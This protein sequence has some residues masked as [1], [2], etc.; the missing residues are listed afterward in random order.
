MKRTKSCLSRF[1]S[2][3]YSHLQFLRA[4][5]HSVGAHRESLRHAAVVQPRVNS[6]SSSSDDQDEDEAS[7]APVPALMTSAASE[8]AAAAAALASDDCCQTCV[9]RGATC[10]R[11]IGAVRSCTVLR[12]LCHMYAC[13]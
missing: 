13:V 7:Q 12:I 2:R 1:D 4:V 3:A 11:H 9:P 8:S 10:W 5:S 6:S